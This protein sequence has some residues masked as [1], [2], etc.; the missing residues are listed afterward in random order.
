[1]A[2]LG[3]NTEYSYHAG[4]LRQRTVN[5]YAEKTPS[6][7]EKYIMYPRQG[8]VVTEIVG[9]GPIRCRTTWSDGAFT[10]SGGQV[11]YGPTLIGNIPGDDLCRRASSEDYLVI[12]SEGKVYNVT[13]TAVAQITDPDLFAN[14][15]DV[16]Y[17]SGRFVYF[18]GDSSQF[19]WSAVGDPTTIDGLD[20]AT[21]DE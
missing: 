10:V 12:V 2:K 13:T 17:L 6:G 7:P 5:M 20:F 8:L 14:V 9:S 15:V 11:Y 16:L 19:Q 4:G 1:M 18:S 21:A 3:L